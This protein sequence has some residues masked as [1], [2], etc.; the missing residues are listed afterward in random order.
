[1]KFQLKHHSIILMVGPTGSG[2]TT[3]VGALRD[4]ISAEG[5]DWRVLSSDTLRR[6]LLGDFQVHKHDPKMLEVSEQAFSLLFNALDNVTSF[7]V[8]TPFV[9]VD[10]RGMDAEFRKQIIAVAKKNHYNLT[11]CV[12]DFKYAGDYTKDIPEEEQ[13]ITAMDVSKFRRKCLPEIRSREFDQIIKVKKRL[14]QDEIELEIVDDEVALKCNIFNEGKLPVNV[15][16]DVHECADQLQEIT[17]LLKPGFTALV[18]DYLDKGERT[19]DTLSRVRLYQLA[20][21]IVVHGNHESYIYRRLKGEIESAGEEIEAKYFTALKILQEN[22]VLRA[23][24]FEIYEN[25]QPFLRIETPGQRTIFVTHAPCE[26][27]YLGKLSFEAQR[28]QR[29][30]YV[31][32]READIRTQ[33]NFIYTQA[34]NNHPLHVFG[35]VC[36]NSPSLAFRNKIFLDTGAVHGGKLTAFTIENDHYNFVSVE[37]PKIESQIKELP[38]NFTRLDSQEKTFNIHDYDLSTDDFKFLDRAMKNG[39][40]YISGTMAPAPSSNTELEPLSEAFNYFRKRGIKEVVLEPKY[41][42]SRCQI[43][44]FKDKLEDCFAVSRNGYRINRVEGLEEELKRWHDKVYDWYDGSWNNIILDGELLPWAAL[45]RGL[46]DHQFRS[47]EALVGNEVSTLASD[48]EFLKLDIAEHYDGEGRLNEL[49]VFHETLNLYGNEGATEFRA[50]NILGADK[51]EVYGN[52]SDMFEAV[53]SENFVVVNLEDEASMVAGQEFF[54]KLTIEGGME[55]VVVKPECEF[56]ELPENTPEY[57]KVR[58]ER[59]LTLV[60]GYDYKRRYHKLVSQK[61]I[62]GK[63][64]VSIRESKIARSMLSADEPA[65]RQLIVIMISELKKEHSLDPRL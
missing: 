23:T 37:G 11:C 16:G 49:G 26:T 51:R 32:D 17:G 44:L 21:L 22:E 8:N 35:H 3:L 4:K 19:A 5:I 1:M 56:H 58:N 9:F 45:G 57:M 6:K 20:G 12:M 62:S 25:S 46:I 31:K 43:Y 24:F 42:G 14:A 29:N 18:G 36:H 39:V 47:Y 54:N 30:L 15:I 59:Y 65:R 38:T 52:P 2:K 33:M 28:A 63:V 53:G 55:G 34:R 13:K 7:P 48:E 40:K 50:F 64:A 41:M 27:K 61:N 10:T 60:Y